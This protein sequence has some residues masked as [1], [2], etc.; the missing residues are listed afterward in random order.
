VDSHI[1]PYKAIREVAQDSIG[2]RLTQSIKPATK[3]CDSK[4]FVKTSE[5]RNG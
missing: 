1:G 4:I 3:E 5:C 2:R